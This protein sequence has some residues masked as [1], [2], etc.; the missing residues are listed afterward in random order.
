[1]SVIFTYLYILYVIYV[2]YNLYV[3]NIYYKVQINTLETHWTFS[4]Y[5]REENTEPL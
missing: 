5:L 4:M 3:Y 1:M 2:T